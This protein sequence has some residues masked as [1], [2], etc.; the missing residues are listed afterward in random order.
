MCMEVTNIDIIHPRVSTTEA[1]VLWVMLIAS[2]TQTLIIQPSRYKWAS[3]MLG[4]C[5]SIR[6][7]C[8]LRS[9]AKACYFLTK[10]AGFLTW[11]IDASFRADALKVSFST[12]HIYL[13]VYSKLNFMRGHIT[14]CSS[15][16]SLS[17]IHQSSMFSVWY[18]LADPDIND[19]N[20]FLFA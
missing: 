1:I 7:I 15:H 18:Y 17:S 20:S 6:G 8:L 16:Y 10:Q 3:C 13:E 12:V 2:S 19:D 11:I 9:P 14:P 4:D 5:C